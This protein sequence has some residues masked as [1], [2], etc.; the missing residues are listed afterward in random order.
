MPSGK[1][2]LFTVAI[3]LVVLYV[4]KNNWFGLAQ[5]F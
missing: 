3:T 4:V 5:Y 1:H 2:I